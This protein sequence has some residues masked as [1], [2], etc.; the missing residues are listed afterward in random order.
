MVLIIMW[1]L[2]HINI[3]CNNNNNK[4][5]S[6]NKNKTTIFYLTQLTDN[7]TCAAISTNTAMSS[8]ISTGGPVPVEIN[9]IMYKKIKLDRI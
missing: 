5:N 7:P 1:Y 8:S 2:G 3:T 4:N 9:N 6:N